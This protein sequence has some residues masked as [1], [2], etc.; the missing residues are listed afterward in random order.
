MTQRFGAGR[1]RA[2]AP[3]LMAR[4]GCGFGLVGMVCVAI[5]L[6]AASVSTTAF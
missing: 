3:V 1:W 5:R 4:Y 6:I 2:Y